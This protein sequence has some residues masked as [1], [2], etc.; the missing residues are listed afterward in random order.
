MMDVYFIIG[1]TVSVSVYHIVNK[2]TLTNYMRVMS[3]SV[4]RTTNRYGK[5]T[6]QTD[7][8]PAPQRALHNSH[9]EKEVSFPKPEM[10]VV[11]NGKKPYSKG[12][13]TYDCGEFLRIRVPIV[14][15]S[16][17]K[18]KNK[19]TGNYLAG[20]SYLQHEY[21]AKTS[22]GWTELKALENAVEQCKKKGYLKGII[23]KEDF[24][25]VYNDVFSYDSQLRAEG[26]AEGEAK[27]RV[28]GEAKGMVKVAKEM[29]A[30]GEPVDKIIKYTGLTRQEI[31]N[32]RAAK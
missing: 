19:N 9:I 31:E 18:L 32:L 4:L 1:I 17:D 11:Y 24:I 6:A 10:Y 26:K 22:E 15:I 30:N 3:N 27:G 8:A 21:E 29:L 16:Y 20:Y 28:E 12:Y 14:E 5:M 7:A 23:E 2:L 25:T 13:E